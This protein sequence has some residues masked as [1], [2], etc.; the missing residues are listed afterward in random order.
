[1]GA[2]RPG[3]GERRRLAHDPHP[4]HGPERAGDSAY[5]GG[6]RAR[7]G[8]GGHPARHRDVLAQRDADAAVGTG[9]DW[10]RARLLPRPERRG[11]RQTLAGAARVGQELEEAGP[12]SA[13]EP[14]RRRVAVTHEEAWTRLP[15][16]LQDRDDSALLAHVRACPDCQRQLFLLG[17]VDRL[18][19]ANLDAE[20]PRSARRP[21]GRRMLAAG[22]APPPPPAPAAAP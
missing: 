7:A 1:G 18:L 8:G 21:R 17:R 13:R 2:L 9:T 19:R 14:A 3:A 11:D 4:A 15:D 22:P 5:A 6:R 16:L 10:D 20:L 12:E